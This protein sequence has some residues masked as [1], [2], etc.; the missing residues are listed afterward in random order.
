MNISERIHKISESHK[1]CCCDDCKDIRELI[2][3]IE[4]YKKALRKYCKFPEQLV[5]NLYEEEQNE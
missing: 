3:Y 2:E 5:S 4:L 1:Y